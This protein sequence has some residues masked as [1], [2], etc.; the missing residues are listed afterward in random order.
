MNPLIKKALEMAGQLIALAY[1]GSLFINTEVE[2]R[3]NELAV[4]PPDPAE[5]P[6]V[7]EL[8]ANQ[9]NIASTVT[10]VESKVDAFAGEFR[11]YLERQAGR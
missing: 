3:M 6:I 8:K 5:A 1:I 11:A 10:R 2:R 4:A 9:R 7:V